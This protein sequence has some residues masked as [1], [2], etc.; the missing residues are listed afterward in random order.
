MAPRLHCRR[1][2]ASREPET[3]RARSHLRRRLRPGQPGTGWAGM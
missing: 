2:P 3:D 1:G